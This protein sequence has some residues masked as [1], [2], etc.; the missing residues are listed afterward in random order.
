M[1][2]DCRTGTGSEA[3]SNGGNG[4][5][6]TLTRNRTGRRPSVLR[7]MRA[8][9]GNLCDADTRRPRPTHRRIG[10]PFDFVAECVCESNSRSRPRRR[11]QELGKPPHWQRVFLLAGM[12]GARAAP[13]AA[14]P[15]RGSTRRPPRIGPRFTRTLTSAFA[16][17]L[18]CA[19]LIGVAVA[20]RRR[21]L[22][23]RPSEGR[24]WRLHRCC[25][26]RGG[27]VVDRLA[28][29]VA[30][31]SEPTAN[32]SRRIAADTRNSRGSDAGP[33]I[34]PGPR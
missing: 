18:G 26:G 15:R 10:N 21:V 20:R 3:V 12:R 1:R 33:D 24:G 25:R 29:Q 32:R 9:R 28:D 31:R 30:E 4:A 6:K 2:V 8:Q 5:R 16:R 34:R 11:K 23:G 19:R 27:V 17:R 13:P 14:A 7:D 22:F